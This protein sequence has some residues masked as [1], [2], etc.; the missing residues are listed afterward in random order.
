MTHYDDLSLFAL[1]PK[2]SYLMLIDVDCPA[3]PSLENISMLDSVEVYNCRLGGCEWLEGARLQHFT[4]TTSDIAD[5][6]PLSSC[7]S[8]TGVWLELRDAQNCDFSGFAPRKL[9]DLSIHDCRDDSLDLSGLS[10]C[11]TLM[12]LSLE[13]LPV[14]N[15][16]FLPKT[17]YLTHLELIRM[18]KLQDISALEGNRNL[19]ELKIDECGALTDVSA[20]AGAANLRELEINGCERLRDISPLGD[21]R[22]LSTLEI[23]SE[24]IRDFSALRGCSRL[25]FVNIDARGLRDA[26][27][28]SEMNYLSELRLSFDSLPNVDFLTTLNENVRLKLELHGYVADYAGLAGPGQYYSLEIDTS[29]ADLERALVY[30]QGTKI[31][32]LSL[33]HFKEADWALV[34]RPSEELCIVLSD[35]RDLSGMPA[36]DAKN[37]T[38]TL[39]GLTR[40]RSLDGL[41][42]LGGLESGT[43][44]LSFSRC[45]ALGDVSALEGAYLSSLLINGAV[46]VPELGGFGVSRLTLQ[47]IA[48]LPDLRCLDGLDASRPCEFELIGLESLR[49]LSALRRFSGASLTVPPQLA[50]QAQE[51]VAAGNFG[52]FEIVYPEGGWSAEDVELTIE[53]LDELET[54]S[55]ALLRHVKRLIVAGEELIDPNEN[56]WTFMNWDGNRAVP[57]LHYGDSGE[58]VEMAPGLIEDLSAL[59]ALTGLEELSLWNQPLA[60]LEGIQSFPSLH[61]LELRYCENLTDVSA[62]FT[63][64]LEALSLNGSP[65][66]SIRGVQNLE[67]LWA[68]DLSDTAVNDLSP[69]AGMDF[70]W[71]ARE[72]GG[73]ELQISGLPIADYGA[74]SSIEHLRY[75][76][77]NGEDS[78]LWAEALRGVEI[79]SI[80]FFHSSFDSE[81][82]AAFVREHP[83]LRQLHMPW[84]ESIDDLTVLL[85]LPELAYV[86]ISYSMEGAVASLEGKELGFELIVE[87]PN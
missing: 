52:S 50:E 62:A 5:F 12:S 33:W 39:D 65:V 58:D 34:P 28:L 11:T 38:L 31:R 36:W 42:A 77:I 17:D 79:E 87:Q 44:A 66:R 67:H 6:S 19:R 48:E 76:D 74:L 15:L 13:R 72:R 85:E 83:E 2:L 41:E 84:N 80:V 63:L 21:C 24:A 71:A 14:E 35:L 32:Q 37:F 30:L 78:A 57:M 45:T 60:S 54:L 49:D 75:L 7:K 10:E 46:A 51:L 22:S 56:V 25:K 82:F 40:L 47:N 61:H 20:L 3:F 18:D 70:A 29:R 43:T 64:D 73:M 27:F 59:S 81:S 23:R 9:H 16:D 69:L 68:L 86:D 8:L 1:M 55:P 53:S 4:M 26:S